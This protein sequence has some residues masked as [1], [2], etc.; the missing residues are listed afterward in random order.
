MET[1]LHI[2]GMMCP[3]CQ[4]RVE[5]ALRALPGVADVTVSLTERCAKVTGDVSF[6]TLRG[7]ILQAGYQVIE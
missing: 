1:I 5:K 2:E 4:M 3:H 6:A 7:A